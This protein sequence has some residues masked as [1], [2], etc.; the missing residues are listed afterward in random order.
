MKKKWL[1]ESNNLLDNLIS[2]KKSL[3]IDW[4]VYQFTWT[5]GG[6]LNAHTQ[7]EKITTHYLD[8][9]VTDERKRSHQECSK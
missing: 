2:K 1:L 5:L 6:V 4:P 9:D 8:L 3:S 7:N